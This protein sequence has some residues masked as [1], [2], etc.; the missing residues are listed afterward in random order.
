[1]KWLKLE[2]SISLSRG[3]GTDSDPV[4]RVSE[5]NKHSLPSLGATPTALTHLLCPELL[6]Q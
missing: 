4:L 5:Q 1:M 6:L 3:L 2:L